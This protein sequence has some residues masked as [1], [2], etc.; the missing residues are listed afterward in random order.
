MTVLMNIDQ[1]GN[2]ADFLAANLDLDT[3]EKQ[4]LLEELDVAKRVRLVHRV[5]GES[6]R[7]GPA[8]AQDPGGR[9][10][11]HRRHPAEDVPP[12]ADEGHPQ[13][14]R[15]GRR[16]PRADRRAAP[17]TP[18]GGRPA[19]EG[20]GRG[21]PRA[22]APYGRTPGQPR[23]LGH[24]QLPRAHRRLAVAEDQRG[25]PRPPP[26][27]GD[28]RPRPLRP[29]QGQAPPHR[30]PL[31]PQAQ[32][33]RARRDPLPRRPAGRGQD[34]ARPVRRRR[35]G[36]GVRP[37]EPRRHAR[38]GRDP[39]PP[40]HVHRRHARPDHSG[41][42]PLRH[43][44]PRLHARRGRQARLGLPRRPDLRPA[45]NPRSPGRTPVLR[46]LPRRPFDLSKVMFICTANYAATSR[47]R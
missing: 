43:Q 26:R 29:R 7:D 24:P 17:R 3:Q 25:Q 33:R 20:H 22:R 31:G 21:Q 5:R 6:A 38:R 32:P 16:G 35:A 45:R 14:A 18:R 19:R 47:R 15:R 8:P 30:V 1:P 42:P 39:R 36:P 10:V 13:G 34:L 40:P 37:H 11:L 28:P 12:R 23:V 4:D 9:P 27:S 44:E 2:L 41:N 46:P